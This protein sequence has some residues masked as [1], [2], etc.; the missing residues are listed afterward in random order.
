M[1]TSDIWIF[2]I[3]KRGQELS[4]CERVEMSAVFISILEKYLKIFKCQY[5]VMRFEV[6]TWTIKASHWAPSTPATSLTELNS[7]C[8]DRTVT[9]N[10]RYWLTS[11][12]SFQKERK[13]NFY[14]FSTLASY[15]S[16]KV[17]TVCCTI[18]VVGTMDQFITSSELHLIHCRP[19]GGGWDWCVSAASFPSVQ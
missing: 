18:V 15:S 13:E 19:E 12:K 6:L 16:I 10:T 1:W 9:G 3:K 11:F 5:F 7:K 17:L 14:L 2:S 8:E 4:D